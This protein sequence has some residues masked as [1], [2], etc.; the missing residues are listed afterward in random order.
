VNR[1]LRNT[2][3]RIVTFTRERFRPIRLVTI[4]TSEPVAD[5]DALDH[6]GAVRALVRIHGVPTGYVQVDVANGRIAG[7]RLVAAAMHR[8]RDTLIRHLVRRAL[9]APLEDAT[10]LRDRLVR[11]PAPR[12]LEAEPLVTVAVCTRDRPADLRLCLEGLARLRWPRLE[13]LVIDNA[14]ATEASRALVETFFPTVRYVREL[15]PGLDWARN[16]AI[17]EARGEILAYADDDVVVDPEWVDA[18]VEV[19]TSDPQVMAITGLVVPYE[20]ET[21]AQAAFEEHRGYEGGFERTWNRVDRAAGERAAVQHGAV[22]QLGT[23]ANMAYRRSIFAAIGGFDPALDVGTATQGGGDLEMFFRVLKEGYLLV[24]EPRAMVYH[25]HRRTYPELRA[26]ISTWGIGM[27]SYITRSWRRY[28][29]ERVGFAW[30]VIRWLLLRNVRRFLRSLRQPRFR[31]ELVW[32]ETKRSLLAPSHYGGA[33]RRAH[34]IRAEFGPEPFS[35]EAP[36]PVALPPRTRRDPRARRRVDIADPLAPLTDVAGAS[37]TEVRVVWNGAEIGSVRIRNGG[38]A[39]SPPRLR[40]AVAD[41]L[42][43]HILAHAGIDPDQVLRALRD[44][45]TRGCMR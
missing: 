21:E 24:R 4:E 20:L 42:A 40:D 38:Q 17:A 36:A 9:D 32:D 28:P 34:Q 10:A 26:Q 22:G 3:S 23:G 29:D 19:F 13:I 37:E 41:G 5:L 8:H 11:P 44:G 31:R 16:R 6:Y 18:L 2:P 12:T 1:P 25:R 14:P 27:Y 33:V 43:T 35:D 7:S 45:P 39:I 15:R 30:I